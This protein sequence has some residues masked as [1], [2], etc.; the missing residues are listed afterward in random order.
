[1]NTQFYPVAGFTRLIAWTSGLLVLTAVLSGGAFA[2]NY[3]LTIDEARINITGKSRPAMAVNKSIPAPT[4]HFREG[5]NVTIN[6]TNNLSTSTSIHWHGFI[7][8]YKMDGVPGISFPGIKPGETFTYRFKIRQSG[9]YWYH[10]HSGLQEQAGIYGAI[11]ILPA[12]K[13]RPRYDRDYVI[14]LSDWS[15]ERPET[16]L[17]NLKKQSDYYN[18]NQRT[19]GDFFRDVGKNGLRATVSDRLMWG[20]MRMTPTDIAD[21]TRYTFLVNGDNPKRNW[22]GLFKPGE[23]IRLRFINGSAMSYFDVAIP[24]LKM[25]VVAADGQN[26][27]PVPVDKFRIAVA[28]TYDVIVQPRKKAAYRNIDEGMDK[29]GYARATLA[30]R[31][32]ME[33]PIPELGKRPLLT[34]ADM[35]M[36]HDMGSKPMDGM[37][38]AAIGHG[39]MA[40]KKTPMPEPEVDHAAMGHGDMAKIKQPE[41]VPAMDHAAMG[42]MDMGNTKTKQ[43]MAR[44]IPA[45]SKPRR[46]SRRS[47]SSNGIRILRYSDLKT[48]RAYRRAKP[49][50]EMELRLTGNMER[51]FWSIN[52]KKFS[53]AEP[54]RFRHNERVRVKFVNTTMMNHPMHLHGHWMELDNGSGNF[55]PRKHV[56]NVEPG[57]TV[58]FDMTADAMGEW[59]FHCHLLYHMATGMF[60]K[61]I[62]EPAQSS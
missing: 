18:Y 37:D 2:G 34:M 29:S 32:G 36:D 41:P 43:P 10:S 28:E 12:R 30:L 51:Y 7:L 15:D 4:L 31:R 53:E 59:A 23:K 57:K 1:M 25:K 16:I 58:Y 5:E 61:V 49:E 45:S 27:K 60:R 62:V 35:G 42:H 50:R 52:G 19:V 3:D 11:V 56:I 9:T 17:D 22:T 38:H 24:G 54:V 8:P 46:A 40:L 39:D 48:R 21:V 33:A 26:V 20:R 47:S 55:R 13:E 14:L 44:K 6:V